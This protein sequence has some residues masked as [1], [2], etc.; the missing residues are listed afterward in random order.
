[1]GSRSFID[2]T[3]IPH[4]RVA[5]GLKNLPLDKQPAG[6][7][8]T[9]CAS[10]QSI[11]RLKRA[12]RSAIQGP[13]SP[14]P[15]SPAIRDKP[16]DRS[17]LMTQRAIAITLNVIL[18][19]AASAVAQRASIGGSI[20]GS[21]VTADGKAAADARVEVRAMSTG[22]V[23]TSTYTNF[24]GTFDIQDV[25]SGSYEVVVTSGLSQATETASVHDD[26]ANVTIRLPNTAGGNSEAGSADTV[27]VAQ[28]KV[29]EKARDALKKARKA[30]SKED[31][32]EA[33]KQ[34]NH[35]LELYPDFAEAL[36]FRSLLKLDAGQVDAALDDLQAATNADSSYPMAYLIL[37]AAFNAKSRFDDSIRVLDRGISLAPNSWQGYFELAKAYLGKQDV[38]AALKH[39]NKACDLAPKE[40]APIHLIRANIYLTLK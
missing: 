40:Y 13:Q 10:S 20:S 35:A 33:T 8:L 21:A 6:Y 25:P 14:L 37:G 29:P 4:A 11:V 23:I 38:N 27:S 39:I 30:L 22:R 5:R 28:M 15:L 19:L 18:I 2:D 32:A 1:M 3:S 7:N 24:A 26:A 9:R 34:V 17:L 36:T 31:N 16:V 12:A